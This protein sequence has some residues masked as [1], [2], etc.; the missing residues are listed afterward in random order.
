MLKRH[1]GM[2]LGA[3]ALCGTCEAFW[4]FRDFEV[5]EACPWAFA[6]G[7]LN[8]NEVEDQNEYK[9]FLGFF[10]PDTTYTI[11]QLTPGSTIAFDNDNG[12]P[13]DPSD[14]W[15]IV[16][17]TGDFGWYTFDLNGDLTTNQCG[18]LY[19]EGTFPGFFGDLSDR[20]LALFAGL[21]GQVIIDADTFL[22]QGDL[23]AYGVPYTCGH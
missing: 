5:W 19:W 23:R 16:D 3:L 14:D 21:T 2:A 4:D 12:T 11:A 6:F 20:N 7:A 10:S 13:E 15:W 17:E 9:L 1:I 22:L 8:F 18:M